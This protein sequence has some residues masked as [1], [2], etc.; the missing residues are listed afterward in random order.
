MVHYGFQSVYLSI[1]TSLK[2]LLQQAKSHK[3]LILTGHSLGA[4]LTELAAPDILIN[5]GYGVIPEVQNFAGPRVGNP[6]FADVFDVHIDTAFRIVNIWDIVPKV[7]PTLAS[8]E[9]A[10]LAV[11]IDGGFTVDELVAHSLATSY[12]PGLVKLIPQG[13]AKASSLMATVAATR[14]YANG[15]PIG[16]EV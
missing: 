11:N 2:N 8:F 16:R 4:A 14:N 12:D 15:L 3:R 7:P 13:G 1:A 9:H 10:G 6:D 5:N